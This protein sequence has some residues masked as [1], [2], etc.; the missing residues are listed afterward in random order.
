MITLDY[1]DR[2]R[3]ALKR[4]RQECQSQRG[5]GVITEAEAGV[6]PFLEETMSLGTQTTFTQ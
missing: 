5:G 2:H 1:P 6:M 4:G 3:P